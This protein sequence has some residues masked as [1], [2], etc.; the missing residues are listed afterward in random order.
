L[1]D[2]NNYAF[3]GCR[4][5]SSIDIPV[6]VT[7]IGSAAFRNC[8]SLSSID[9]PVNVISID[10][11]AFQDCTSLVSVISR[12]LTPPTMAVNPNS[13]DCAQIIRVPAG[14]VSAYKSAQG[15]SKY[16]SIIAAIP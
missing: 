16:E 5:L 14:S 11:G 9:I 1:A 13:F 3:Y 8:T 7:S 10:G 12:A 4:S 15:W 6:N 2:I